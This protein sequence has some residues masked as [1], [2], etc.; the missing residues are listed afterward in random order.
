MVLYEIYSKKSKVTNAYVHGLYIF[1]MFIGTA[2][3]LLSILLSEGTGSTHRKANLLTIKYQMKSKKYN[4]VRTIQ[5]W[6]NSPKIKYQNTTLSEQSLDQ[7]SKYNT[8]RTVPRSN[9]KIVERGKIDTPNTQ[10]HN[11]LRSWF[12]TGI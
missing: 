8:V 5:H 10:I 6:Q 4:T 11:R 12:C 1:C 9:I 7:I 3:S 2:I